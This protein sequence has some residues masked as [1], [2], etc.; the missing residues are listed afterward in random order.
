MWLGEEVGASQ[1]NIPALTATRADVDVKPGLRFRKAKL[2][3]VGI[4]VDR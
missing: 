4:L 2:A 1:R 3:W